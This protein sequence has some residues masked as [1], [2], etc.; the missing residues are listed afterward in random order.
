MNTM[1][2][3]LRRGTGIAAILAMSM[4]HPPAAGS[5]APIPGR[6]T[7][8]KASQWYDKQPWLVGCNFTPS[9][10][11]NQLEMWQADTFDPA[12]S[13][14]ELGWAS[15]IGMNTVRVYLH[16]LLWQQ[17]PEGFLKRIDQ[18]LGIADK[19]GIKTLLVLLDSCWGSFPKPGTQPAPRPHVHNSGWVQC[20]HIDTLTNE[21]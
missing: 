19:H 7:V 5:E 14:R 3:F 17:D 8:E 21:R 10:A 20:P 4:A 15:G 13:D 1:R 6:W 9:T 2:P 16:D 18:F 11:I 12:T